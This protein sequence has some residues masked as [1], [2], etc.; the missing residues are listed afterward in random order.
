MDMGMFESYFCSKKPGKTIKS[1]SSFNSVRL[2][3]DTEESIAVYRVECESG[4][5]YTGRNNLN[6]YEDYRKKVEDLYDKHPLP[7]DEM[8][9][10]CIN[11]SWIFGFESLKALYAWVS[12]SRVIKY[13][14]E[15]GYKISKYIVKGESVYKDDDR[16]LIFSLGSALKSEELPLLTYGPAAYV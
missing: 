14:R 8:S 11:E 3:D 10:I 12:D 6:T 2:K 16:Q 9:K 1:F 15:N 7:S 5:M 4:G 13:L